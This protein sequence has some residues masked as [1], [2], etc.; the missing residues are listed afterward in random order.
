MTFCF[1]TDTTSLVVGQYQFAQP[2]AATGRLRFDVGP[3]QFVYSCRVATHW[4]AV[5]PV[6]QVFPRTVCIIVYVAHCRI[7][8]AN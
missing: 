5:F 2:F 8:A 6:C 1:D 7:N 3:K 4:T